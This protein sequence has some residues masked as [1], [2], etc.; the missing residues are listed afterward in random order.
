MNER[1]RHRTA[2]RGRM[3][4]RSGVL[5]FSIGVYNS[6]AEVGRVI[7]LARQVGEVPSRLG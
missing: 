7:E 5:R 3:A 4:V 6:E 2:K 1:Y